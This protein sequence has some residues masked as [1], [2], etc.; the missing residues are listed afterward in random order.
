VKRLGRITESQRNN[1]KDLP[2]YEVKTIADCWEFVSNSD[3]ILDIGFGDGDFTISLAE[4]FPNTRIIASEVYKSGIGSLLGKVK[5]KDI[6]DIR[7]FPGD[8]RDIL[9]N[10]CKPVFNKVFV[11]FPD[12]W[13]KARHHKRRLISST[14]FEIIRPHLKDKAEIFISTDWENYSESIIELKDH[15]IDF[16]FEEGAFAETTF[17]TRFAKRAIKEGRS[18]KAFK[19]TLL[20]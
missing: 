15:L 6:E 3:A 13:Q 17:E 10:E 20:K 11:M 16:L 4:K 7:V 5:A 1:L 12:P 14:F 2:F 9:I 18:I 19:F 8:V